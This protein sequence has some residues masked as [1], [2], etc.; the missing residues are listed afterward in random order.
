MARARGRPR[1][2]RAGAA[3]PQP[4]W[5]RLVNPYRPLEILD[6]EGVEAIHDA[7]M[8]VLEECGIEFL[9]EEALRRLARAGADV[10][11]ETRLVRFDRALIAEQV[12]RA[13]SLFT[14]YARNPERHVPL[15]AGHLAFDTVGG[16]PN[17]AD[18]DRG[19]RP[20]CARAFRDFV[21]LGHCLNV[22][23]LGGG[24][25]IAPVDL[26]AAS[27]HLDCALAFI[28]LSDRAW[29]T[30]GIGRERV[31]DAVEMLRIARGLEHEALLREPGC[32]TTINV[33]SPRRFDASMAEGLIAMAEAGQALSVTPFTLAGAMSPVTLAGAL[34]QQNAE[35]LAGV[36]L[37]QIV[38]PG[39]PVLYGGFTS[40]AD[41]R[42]GGPA[43]G[44][45]EQAQA[46]LASGQLAR[47]Y[48][49]PFRSSNANASNAVDAQAAYESA[50]SIW[51]A[52]MGHANL[53]HHGAGWLEGG[54]TASF[55]KAIVDAEMLQMMAAFLRPLDTGP[56][57]LAL[58]AIASVAPG[59]HF[60]GAEHTLARF[61][62]A[63]YTPLLSDWRNYEA[64]ARDG[65]RSATERANAIWKGLLA[66]Y[67]APPLD[68]GIAEALDEF[69]ARRKREIAR[70]VRR[71]E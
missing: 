28:T 17:G 32:F 39:T 41:L 71:P 63:F 14:L 45:P 9:S 31:E 21:R 23:H 44:T 55:E 51:S 36:A 18:L 49:L 35:A 26:D 29:H 10:D 5:S 68:P 27:R 52:V 34:V 65:A 69:V 53:L 30:T 42:S 25:P 62:S 64:W 38:R 11:R 60:F 8:R 66:A 47:R 19:R 2:G 7:S 67:E 20:G 33:N 6:E 43:F 40:N 58:E 48:G 70:G 1:R 12:A 50:M 22:L 15:G 3:F 57:A 13:P 37:A 4:P 24:V 61:R 59:G 46:G 54:L 16:P 56:E